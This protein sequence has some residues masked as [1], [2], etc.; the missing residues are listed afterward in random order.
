MIYMA[1]LWTASNSST[2]FLSWRRHTWT[3]YSR[4]VALG[5][6]SEED[7]H[8]PHPAGHPSF[9]AAQDTVGLLGYKHT[10]LAHVQL[11]LYQDTEV[12]L[13]RAVFIMFFSRFVQITEIALAPVQHFALGLAE[14]H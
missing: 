14:S 6:T 13:C 1:F 10:L 2:S 8:L 7:N 4:W 3:G 9:D 11:F 5:H 12:L